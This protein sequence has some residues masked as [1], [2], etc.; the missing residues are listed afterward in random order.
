MTALFHAYTQT[1]ADG[2]ATSV[3]RPS[4]WNSAHI[5][6]QTLSG[7][8]LGPASISGTNIV[9]QGGSNITLSATTDVSAATI[10]FNAATFAQTQQ[11]MYFSASGTNTSA[12]TMQFGDTNGVSFSLSNGSVIATVATNYMASN[13]S[14]NFVNTSQS[15]LFQQTSATSA[16]T[17]AAFP[18]ANTTNFAG[19]GFTS[20]TTAGTAV[21]A[22]NG[23]NG[24]SMAMPAFITTYAN[25]LTSGRAGTG[26]TLALTN[27]TGT[28]S[29]NT[30]GVALSLSGNAGG[31]GAGAALQGSGT[32]TQNSGTIQFANSNGVTFGLSTNQMTASVKTDYAGTGYTSTTQAGSTVGVTL[33]TSGLSAAWP[34][35]LTTYAAQ[36]VDTNKAGTGFTSTTTAGT[37]VVGTL[38][39]NGLSLGVPAYITTYAAQTVQ[40]QNLHNVTLSGNTSG[41]LAQISSGT[42]TLAGGNNITLSQVGNAITISGVNTVAQTVDT[43]KAGTGFTSTTT[44]GTAVV[45]TLNTSG[46]SLG[47]P[48]YLT[49]Y[50]AQTVQTQNLHNVT[51]SGNTS[52]TLAQISSGT[53]TLAGGNNITLSQVGNA[54]TISGVNT[55][56]QTVDTNKAGTGYTSTTQAGSTVGVTLNTSGLSAAWPPFITTYAAQTVDTNKAGTGFTSTTTAGTAI[57]GTLNTSGLSLGVP[58]YLTTYVA[59]TVQTQNL[60]NITLSGNTSGTLAQVS[61]GTLT[62]A[63]GNNITLSQVGNA[64]TISGVNT[65]AQTVDTNKAGTGYTSTTQAGTTVGVTLNTSGLSAAWP[66]FITTYVNDLTSGRAGTGTTFGGTNIS[67]SLTLNTNGLAL[68]LS[69]PA[70][71]LLSRVIVPNYAGLTMLSAPTNASASV[72]VVTLPYLSGSRMDL[73]LYQSLASSATANTYGQQLSIYM[74]IYTN[75]T[76]NSRLMSLSSGSTQT[77]YTLASNTA[78]ATQILGSGI[79]PIS[80]PVNFSVTPGEYFIA[81]NLVTNTFSSGTATTALGQ[82]LSIVGN[83][84]QSA[85]W[86]MVQDYAVATANTNN[87]LQPSGVFSAASTGLPATISYSQMTMTGASRLQANF[88][89]VM[90]NN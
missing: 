73:L 76:L 15:S 57:V 29:V 79:R 56:A 75:D 7:N 81:A 88:A 42:L 1:V 45:G 44:A 3:V 89:V 31:A 10:I 47:V 62:L 30:N 26:T 65:V 90:R 77:T 21:V 48:A 49:T 55:V 25:D 46:L 64:I 85:S 40:T 19:T 58:A 37:A 71:P 52:G 18:S 16:I 87:S 6:A 4:D 78:G 27:L 51:L 54:I 68:S 12:N 20:T 60:H 35:F 28:L 17:S 67:G 74:G 50:A 36:T 70:A 84:M 82:T 14:S 23:T 22:T 83:T 61:S 72:N 43:N 32:Y 53:L 8:Y 80:C 5:Q 33:N 63:G 11:P 24:L 66:P 39:T 86:A 69:A 34:P 59:Q 41:T 9:F 13:Q 38:N 2:T